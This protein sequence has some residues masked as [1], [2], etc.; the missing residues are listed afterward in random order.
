M[1]NYVRKDDIL[2]KMVKYAE[3]HGVKKNNR[4]LKI[5]SSVLQTQLEAYVVRNFFDDAGFYPVLNIADNTL[6]EAVAICDKGKVA[7]TH[8]LKKS[9]KSKSNQTPL[10]D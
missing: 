2:D 1:Q 3:A 5:S 9:A 6:R 8:Y 4:D 7:Y 10:L